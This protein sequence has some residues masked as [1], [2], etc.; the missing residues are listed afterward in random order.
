MDWP[1]KLTETSTEAVAAIRQKIDELDKNSQYG[2]GHTVDFGPFVKHGFLGAAYL[3]IAA[4]F[5][6]WGW[7][8]QDMQGLTVADVGCFT[9]G[10]TVL[11][12]ARNAKKV[13]AI[14]ELPD[15]LAQCA[16][17]AEIFKKDNVQTIESSAY[18]LS[19]H[20]AEGSLDLIVLSG[21]LYHM[22]DMLVG[23]YGL[24][25]LL[26]P[27]GTLLIETNA[28]NDFKRSYANFGRFCGGMWW[29]PSGICV[30]DMC[31]YMGFENVD[32]RFYVPG[33]CLVR[34][35]KSHENIPFKRG[36]NWSFDTLKDARPRTMDA[37][38][39]APV[40][41]ALYVRIRRLLSRV[42]R[43]IIR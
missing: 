22:S 15:H 21:V 18:R 8:K 43:R 2:W 3:D 37:T 41:T 32:V 33:R 16:Y 42:K 28:V 17:M 36:M 35:T 20:I 23:L 26:K 25:K 27:N 6:K 31:E 30:K 14:D 24:N 1:L 5:D 10:I 39:M 19:E 13:Y 9:G 11:M 34:A 7:W 40:H 4:N 38:T 12:A 29:Q